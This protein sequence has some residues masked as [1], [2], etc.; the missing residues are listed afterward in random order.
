MRFW[1]ALAVGMF[2]LPL[3][4]F[5]GVPIK[6]SD[7][8]R[9]SDFVVRAKVQQKSIRRDGSGQIVTEIKLMVNE[10]WKGDPKTALIRVV[11]PGGTLGEAREFALDDTWYEI[12]EEVVA[13]LVRNPQ[14]DAVTLKSAQGKFRVSENMAASSA[15][16]LSLSEL[17]QRVQE[18]G[19]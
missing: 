12:S 4:A 7:L 16:K 18:A 6:I 19:Q 13:F 8:A 2:L 9:G 5:E 3:N 11:E 15:Q 10:C 1:L 14:G 17:K